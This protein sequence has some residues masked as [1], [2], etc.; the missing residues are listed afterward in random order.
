[1]NISIIAYF[2]TTPDLIPKP[3]SKLLERPKAN[4]SALNKHKRSKI[5]FINKYSA[6]NIYI[7]KKNNTLWFL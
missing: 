6:P 4:R 3:V 7:N 1:M 5:A 2:T